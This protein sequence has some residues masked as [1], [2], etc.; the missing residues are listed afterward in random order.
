[1]GIHV[2]IISPSRSKLRQGIMASSEQRELLLKLNECR[3]SMFH[4]KKID[5][6]Q[7]AA[8]M[9]MSRATLYRKLKSVTDLTPSEWI[10]EAKMKR[11]AELLAEGRYRAFQV[12]RMLGFTSQSSF[13]KMFL[14][15]Y[16]V[17]PATYQRM[18]VMANQ[19][20][21]PALETTPEQ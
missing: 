20:Y 3:S 10:N 2:M 12:A 5:V 21:A 15:Q 4:Y 6:K 7:L 9:H 8:L 17:T 19:S 13:G 11:A 16:K 18:E 14:K 1:M